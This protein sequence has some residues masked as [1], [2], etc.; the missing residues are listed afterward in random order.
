MTIATAFIRIVVGPQVR[1]DRYE[2]GFRHL[3]EWIMHDAIRFETS[4][5]AG[6]KRALEEHR[7]PASTE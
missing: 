1:A 3:G 4:A 2:L 5:V 7:G 6:S